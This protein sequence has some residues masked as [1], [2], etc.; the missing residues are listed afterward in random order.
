M[1]NLPKLTDLDVANKRVLLR[2]DLDTE[3]NSNDLRIKASVETLNYLKDNGAEII[4]IGHRGRPDG[5]FDESNSIV[6][7]PALYISLSNSFNIS[8]PNKSVIVILTLSILFICH[9]ILLS[10]LIIYNP[11]Q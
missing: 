3:P 8:T 7:C 10:L 1:I 11:R 5:K 4:I 2:L 9:F 6:C